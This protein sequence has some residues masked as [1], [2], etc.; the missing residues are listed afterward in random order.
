MKFN[1]PRVRRCLGAVRRDGKHQGRA[2]RFERLEDR[3]VLAVTATLSAQNEFAFTG[4]GDDDVLELFVENGILRYIGATPPAA[5]F[6]VSVAALTAL[7]IDLGGGADSVRFGGTAPFSLSNGRL[8]ATNVETIRISQSI[9]TAGNQQYLDGQIVVDAAVL[10]SA[11]ANITFAASIDA[12]SSPA[13]AKAAASLPPG[14]GQSFLTWQ[15]MLGRTTADALAASDLDHDGDID[16]DDLLAWSASFGLSAAALNGQIALTVDAGGMAEFLKPVG[17]ITKLGALDVTAG[18]GIRIGAGEMKLDG[19]STTFNSPVVLTADLIITDSGDVTFN[20]TVNGDGAPGGPWALEVVTSNNSTTAFNQP[21][22]AV[23]PLASLT[24]NGDGRTVIAGGAVTTVNLQKYG[25]AVALPVAATLTSA[26]IQFLSTLDGPG[27]LIAAATTAGVVE[28]HGPAGDNQELLSLTAAAG[29]NALLNAPRITTTGNQ[30]YN[31]VVVVQDVVFESKTGAVTF[32][33]QLNGALP[34]QHAVEVR[35]PGLTTFNNLVGIT[36]PLKSLATTG[37]GQTKLDIPISGSQ[38]SVNVAAAILFADNVTLARDTI[39]RSQAGPV[40]FGGTINGT[41]AGVESLRV[42][43]PGATT[44]N[45]RVGN[46]I[47]LENLVTTSGGMTQFNA[48]TPLGLPTVATRFFQR[49]EEP[50]ELGKDTTLQSTDDAIAFVGTVNG[51]TMGQEFLV[52]QAPGDTTFGDRVGNNFRLESLATSGGGRTVFN[53]APLAVANSVDTQGLQDYQDDVVV[54]QD[55]RL[56]SVGGPVTFQ[57]T[58]NGAA[59]NAQALEVRAPGVT[60]FNDLVGNTARLRSLSS[61]G[62]GQTRFNIPISGIQVSVDVGTALG[63]ADDVV[64]ARDTIL[65][66]GGSVDFDAT[67]N[68]TT[69]GTESLEVRAAGLITF[70]GLVGN[71]AAL[72]SLTA[73][74]GLETRLAIPLLT[75]GDASVVTRSFQNYAENVRLLQDTILVSNEGPVTFVGTVNGNTPSQQSLEVRAPGA[76]QFNGRVGNDVRLESLT[77]NG[78]GVTRFNISPLPGQNSVDTQGLQS[79]SDDVVLVQSTRLQSLD[80]P[81]T[82]H[83]TVN[84]AAPDAA[85]FEVRAAGVT[86][87]NDLVGNAARLRSLSTIG[88]GQTTLNIPLVGLQVSID[89]VAALSLSDD[90]V[91]ARDTILRSA[92]GPVSFDATINGA[93]LGQESLEVRSAGFTTF[94]GLVGASVPL[95]NV[96]TSGGTARFNIPPVAGSFSVRTVQNQTYGDSVVLMNHTSLR[97]RDVTF[98]GAVDGDGASGGPWDL[99]VD[100]DRFTRFQ[101]DVGGVSPLRDLI[102]ATGGPATGTFSVNVRLIATRDIAVLVRESSPASTADD[103]TLQAAAQLSAGRNVTLQAGDDL[104]FDSGARIT[105]GGLLRIDGDFNSNDAN[106]TTIEMT[107][108]AVGAD[109]AAG[110][111]SGALGIEIHGGSDAIDVFRLQADRLKT[112]N[113]VKV[114]GYLASP[115]ASGIDEILLRFSPNYKLDVGGYQ[116]DGGAEPGN[117]LL[118]LD[119]SRDTTPRQVHVDYTTVVDPFNPPTP[120]VIDGSNSVITGL[121]TANGSPITVADMEKY[122]LKAGTAAT[123]APDF[124]LIRA[125]DQPIPDAPN[126]AT[127]PAEFAAYQEFLKL[128]QKILVTTDLSNTSYQWFISGWESM[129]LVGSNVRDVIV[130]NT[131]VPALIEGGA[132]NDTLV[133]GSN[134][135]VIFS[136]PG[137]SKTT[138]GTPVFF[139]VGAP[140]TALSPPAPTPNV[141]PGDVLYGVGGDDFLFSDVDLFRDNGFLWGLV[142]LD[143]PGEFDIL[144]GAGLGTSP[145]GQFNHGGQFGPNDLVRNITGTLVDGGG[146]KNVMTWLMATPVNANLKPNMTSDPLNSLIDAAF[147]ANNPA[148][149]MV[150][151]LPLGAVL[152]N[153]DIEQ[154]SYPPPI[155]PASAIDAAFAQWEI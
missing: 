17:A 83:G 6:N 97:G 67:V 110:A 49:Y 104:T 127:Q 33:G 117:D 135:D 46:S 123:S 71:F 88:G 13:P 137:A 18:M 40:T 22:G 69:P 94:R 112:P 96:T 144:E 66:S 82:F 50:V 15:R 65:R 120:P 53:I 118:T 79:Y 90:V 152:N 102:V 8:S 45:G 111:L 139:N 73:R 125:K 85:D 95:E 35:A 36:F 32:N 98:M 146:Q 84:G 129:Q 57:R 25:D 128:E 121:G 21:V 150:G 54:A 133:G 47:P 61:I 77:T 155:K 7:T 115:A 108:P 26:S 3:R 80:G 59:D 100:A 2:A 101:G 14:A 11:N 149:H 91:L 151:L 134:V 126:P 75:P 140:D 68:G 138:A 148:V 38:A 141:I 24:T 143:V 153:F 154:R 4:N 41:T 16:G 93:T 5:N 44:F 74:D 39:L 72:E 114:F 27:A 19:N 28:F 78:G 89:V 142:T 43:A 70:R 63:L 52:V 58:V 42:E 10:L 124:L 31:T 119:H 107:V 87:F 136:G 60:A 132:G 147:R 64:L 48:T 23:Q 92:G 9:N 37:G 62:G 29:V 116:I 106:G 105:A 130:N 145:L 99:S 109:D 55:L 113:L 131:P 76:T 122:F 51:T 20:G 1:G 86:T 12:A 30:V 34:N 81:V 56:Q 103:I